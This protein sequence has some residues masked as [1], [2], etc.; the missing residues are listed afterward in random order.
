[1][2]GHERETPQVPTKPPDRLLQ[3]LE[4]PL[5]VTLILEDGPPLVATGHHV[6]DRAGVFDPQWSGH[7]PILPP[8]ARRENRKP[9][10]TP[11]SRPA[12]GQHSPGRIPQRFHKVLYS[13][14]APDITKDHG[15]PRRPSQS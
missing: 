8:G 1:M 6:M 9:A 5:V 10:L 3:S 13:G 15:V 7:G 2:V 12:H 11:R 4:E 14:L